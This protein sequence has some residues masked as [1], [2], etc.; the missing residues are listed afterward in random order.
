MFLPMFFLL[1]GYNCLLCLIQEWCSTLMIDE[2]GLMMDVDGW[3]QCI[4]VDVLLHEKHSASVQQW[5]KILEAS[6][7]SD[8]W[9][10]AR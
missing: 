6:K 5:N 4:A 8:S 9:T 1:M 3:S 10:A 7:K 2:R